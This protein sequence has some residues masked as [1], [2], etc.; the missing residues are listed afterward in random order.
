MKTLLPQP[1][2]IQ[3]IAQ[4]ALLLFGL[5]MIG[6]NAGAQC[7]STNYNSENCGDQP[8]NMPDQ[9]SVVAKSATNNI[10]YMYSSAG[11]PW[12]NTSN[13]DAMDLAFGAGNWTTAFYES[14]DAAVIFSSATSSVYMEGG[15]TNTNA[16]NT[17]LAGNQAAI[18]AWVNSGGSLL[19]NSATNQDV[20]VTAGFDSTTIVDNGNEPSVDVVDTNH[21]TS[22]GPNAVTVTT[23]TGNSF[24]HASVTGT[25]LN[26]ILVTTGNASKVILAE[27]SFGAGH[28]MVGGMTNANFHTPNADAVNFRVNVLVYMDEQSNISN[29]LGNKDIL[30]VASPGTAAWGDDVV[31]K[32]ESTGELDAEFFNSGSGTPTLAELNE[33][34][35]IYVFTD[36]SPADPAAL[37]NV[38]A[39]YIEGGKGVLDATFTA[40]V[41]IAGNWSQ[42]ELYSASNQQSDD[43]DLGNILLSDDDLVENLNSFTGTY[44]N[45]D[46]T[47]SAN[48]TVVAEYNDGDNTPLIVKASNVGP[49]NVRRVFLNFYPPSS[50]ARNDFW[51]SST[52]GAQMMVNAVKWI[53]FGSDPGL[54]NK[55]VLVIE[56][57]SNNDWAEDVVEKLE[58]TGELDAD[59][60]F[61]LNNNIPTLAEL[62]EY[63]TILFYT[64]GGIQDA[65]AF[66]D[67]LADYIEGGKGVLN[68]AFSGHI[69]PDGGWSQY[70][71]YDATSF[72][73]GSQHTLGTVNLPGDPIMANVNSFDGGSNSYHDINGTLSANATVVAEWSNGN[74]LIVKA[75]DVGP[76]E[77]R[78][79]FLNFFPPSDI[80][81][82]DFWD[83]TTDGAQIMINAVKWVIQGNDV[84]NSKDF[85]T[86]TISFGLYPNPVQDMLNVEMGADAQFNSAEVYNLQGQKVT[87]S[88]QPTV[89]VANL[90]SGIY[91]IKVTSLDGGI[92]TKRFIKK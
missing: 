31:A 71:L 87:A 78:Q 9:N 59:V 16:L 34:K 40:N 42:Y 70:N 69:S 33:Y 79:V 75:D 76:Q 13:S 88:T 66:G 10:Y 12:G 29:P 21:P 20:D 8:A 48:A 19:I 65:T 53:I 85:N 81:R 51:D 91:L 83:E 46:G 18:E 49:Q 55:D 60:F 77:V 47:L 74:P 11:Q 84:L 22:Q 89:N 72:N 54:G 27:K 57:S 24:S 44:R 68:A 82:A 4:R 62:N 6:M 67:I 1:P 61:D 3:K 14:A 15:D 45:T 17:F 26:P 63:K 43:A 28:L 90:S 56:S 32:L 39:Q 7:N 2:F 5:V 92:Q 38:L 73:S 35:T 50:D 25:G 37:G 80:E 86:N 23:F 41:P 64:D 30:V 36:A 52:D 58:S